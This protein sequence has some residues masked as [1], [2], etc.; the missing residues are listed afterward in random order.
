MEQCF[1]VNIG[2]EAFCA[3]LY[4]IWPLLQRHEQE[5]TAVIIE[6]LIKLEGCLCVPQEKSK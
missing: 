2:S 5:Y 1:S 4:G 6:S 3:L